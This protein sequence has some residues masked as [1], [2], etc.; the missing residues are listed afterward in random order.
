M[1]VTAI[2]ETILPA[3]NTDISRTGKGT[4]ATSLFGAKHDNGPE[5]IQSEFVCREGR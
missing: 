3:L 1:Q 5:N 2:T 4:N